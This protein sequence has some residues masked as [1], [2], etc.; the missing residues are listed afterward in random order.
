MTESLRKN[1]LADA[2]HSLKS[3]E[4]D[5]TPSAVGDQAVAKPRNG[6]GTVT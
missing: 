1:G 4:S 2:A 5:A 6:V 3:G